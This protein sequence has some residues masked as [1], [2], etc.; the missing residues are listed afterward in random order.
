MS[1]IQNDYNVIITI[2]SNRKK[3]VLVSLIFSELMSFM[4]A[5]MM[6]LFH[7]LQLQSSQLQS[8]LM[9]LMNDSSFQADFMMKDNCNLS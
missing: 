8:T 6:H 2:V 1:F 4:T 5:L 9:I 3:I 7:M